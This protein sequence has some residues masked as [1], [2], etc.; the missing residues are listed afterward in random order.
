M[1]ECGTDRKFHIYSL[2][3][4]PLYTI[5]A[6]VTAASA[7]RP[8][9]GCFL[10]IICYG[11]KPTVVSYV[12][13]CVYICVSAERFLPNL[14]HTIRIEWRL[15]SPGKKHQQQKHYLQ[16][17]T[18]DIQLT[19]SAMC[20]I[21]RIL[22]RYTHTHSGSFGSAKP[23]PQTCKSGKTSSGWENKRDRGN[24]LGQKITHVMA[25]NE[26]INI[27]VWNVTLHTATWICLPLKSMGPPTFWSRIYVL[28]CVCVQCVYV[29]TYVNFKKRNFVHAKD[30]FKF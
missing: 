12:W 16:S 2:K 11:Y 6:A 10:G 23:N 1:H 15:D 27:L 26:I 19:I 8:G 29:Y 9:F 7:C 28:V 24:I 25:H 17:V 4:I 13:V 30:N 21:V 3:Q 5:G 22:L 14:L 18:V 20:Q